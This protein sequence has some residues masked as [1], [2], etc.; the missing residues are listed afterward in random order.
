M[1]VAP[2]STSVAAT[3]VTASVTVWHWRSRR[4]R[5]WLT[6][7]ASLTAVTVT[8]MTSVALENAVVPPLLLA[9]TRVPA[10]PP[11]RSQARS[12]SA[13]LLLPL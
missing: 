6:T 9:S 13:A 1:K 2:L 4:R 5:R 10:T 12:V 7:G 8:S 3:V 11:V